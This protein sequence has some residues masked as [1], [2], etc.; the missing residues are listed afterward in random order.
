[1]SPFGVTTS[2]AASINQY[3]APGQKQIK[4]DRR[5]GVAVRNIII[6][7]DNNSANNPFIQ[8]QDPALAGGG[9]DQTM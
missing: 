3:V 1:M 7:A 9:R 5:L 4:K 2:D 6:G 8:P